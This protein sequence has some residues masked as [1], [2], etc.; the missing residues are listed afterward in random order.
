MSE[1]LTVLPMAFVMVAGPQII[2]AIILATSRDPRRSS[3]AYVAGVALATTLGVGIAFAVSGWFAD[4]ADQSSESTTNDVIDYLVIALLV[5]LAIRVYIRRTSTEPPAWMSKLQEATPRSAFRLGFLLFM[6]MPTDIITMLT[7]GTYLGRHDLP[8]WKCLPFVAATV[9]L[10]GLPLLV[11]VLMGKKADVLLPRL[12]DWM[13][14]NSWIV[15]E[16]VI[17]FFL[18]MAIS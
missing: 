15:S 2:S 12:R 7:V 4:P 16:V 5:V 8:L 10:A 6:V 11:L 18:V 17:G 9:L 13:G 1:L 3:L 14:T